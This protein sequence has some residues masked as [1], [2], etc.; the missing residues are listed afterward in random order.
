MGK[1]SD[2]KRCRL[3]GDLFESGSDGI[4][5]PCLRARAKARLARQRR[6]RPLR[7]DCGQPAVTVLPVRVGKNGVYQARLPLCAE[8]LAVEQSFGLATGAGKANASPES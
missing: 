5:R 2:T 3:C 8:C 1:N 7:C 4:C 6:Q